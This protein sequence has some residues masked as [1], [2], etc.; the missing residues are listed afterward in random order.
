MLKRKSLLVG[1]LST[2]LLVLPLTNVS[3]KTPTVQQLQA[4]IVSLQNQ[5][6]QQKATISKDNTTISN[7][8]SQ[9]KTSIVTKGSLPSNHY[10]EIDE[11]TYPL[12]ANLE[13]LNKAPVQNVKLTMKD[14][15]QI[16][17]GQNWDFTPHPGYTLIS[18][19]WSSS[20]Y[21]SIETWRIVGV[22]SDN[23]IEVYVNSFAPQVIGVSK[24]PGV[25]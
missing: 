6:N 20:W 21:H 4:Q 14:F 24:G 15:N 10:N 3:A 16:Q 8:Q 22:G 2:A 9:L 1:A 25:N 19:E 17:L 13:I 12:K 5:V 23:W 11:V 7:L 18:R